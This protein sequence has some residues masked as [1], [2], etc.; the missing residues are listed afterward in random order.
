MH[1]GTGAESRSVLRALY[2]V[3]FC[4][5]APCL[6]RSTARRRWDRDRGPGELGVEDIGIQVCA[7]RPGDRAEFGMDSH[8]GEDGRIAQRS[9]DSFKR[10]PASEIQFTRDPIV[11]AQIEPVATQG[12]YLDDILQHDLTLAIE[13]AGAD[14]TLAH[15]PNFPPVPPGAQS[16]PA[17]CSY[18]CSKI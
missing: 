18:P 11:E 13:S 15:D 4:L 6:T 8:L 7:I 12:F 16:W 2:F 1:D 17:P 3:L 14:R 9:E 10:K 5:S